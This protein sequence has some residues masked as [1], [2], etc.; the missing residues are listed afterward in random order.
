MKRKAANEPS[1]PDSSTIMKRNPNE[2][3]TPKYEKISELVNAKPEAEQ[4]RKDS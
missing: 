1:S 2:Q 4:P 3:I